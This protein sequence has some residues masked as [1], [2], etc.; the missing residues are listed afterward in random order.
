MS[1]R[2]AANTAASIKESHMI[3][4]ATRKF[5]TETPLTTL[6]PISAGLLDACTAK[7]YALC[8]TQAYA[9]A[10][11]ISRGLVAAEPGNW[12][13]RT[14]LAVCLHKLHR[15]NEAMQVVDVGLRFQPAHPE[16]LAL[17]AAFT[18]AAPPS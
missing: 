12:Y 7:A 4:A 17:R 16:L 14:L 5:I 15:R 2:V 3:D 1:D 6:L 10:E 11:V 8:A 13:Y 18:P 9:N